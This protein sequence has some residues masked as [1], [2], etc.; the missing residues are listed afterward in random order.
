[1][2]FSGKFPKLSQMISNDIGEFTAEH[3]DVADLTM[4]SLDWQMM[5]LPPMAKEMENVSPKGEDLS[6]DPQDAKAK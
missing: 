1:M 5:G 3:M 4:S 2:I 6:R